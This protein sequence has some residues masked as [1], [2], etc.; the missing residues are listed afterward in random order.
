MAPYFKNISEEQHLDLL[1]SIQLAHAVI[2]VPKL[3]IL[4]F[5]IPMTL[6]II[7]LKRYYFFVLVILLRKG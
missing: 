6:C 5:G 3:K 4:I 1:V 7:L 2:A